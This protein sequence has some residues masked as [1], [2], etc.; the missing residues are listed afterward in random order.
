MPIDDHEVVRTVGAHDAR[1]R[2]S[3][4]RIDAEL[5]LVDLHH[6]PFLREV[7]ERVGIDLADRDRVVGDA[8]R[9]RAVV[10][11]DAMSNSPCRATTMTGARS[12]ARSSVCNVST[13]STTTSD[14][15]QDPIAPTTWSMQAVSAAT[16]AGSMAGNMPMRSWLRPSLR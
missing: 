9:R 15:S 5:A 16:S 11:A 1:T 10:A 7:E 12:G 13:S 14:A 8:G 3:G 4:Q 2:L 6:R